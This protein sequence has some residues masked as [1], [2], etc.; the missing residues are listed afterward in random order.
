[1]K[2]EYTTELENVKA[3]LRTLTREANEYK[4]RAEHAERKNGIDIMNYLQGDRL[5]LDQ[6]REN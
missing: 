3:E 1:M 4:Q 5:P 6:R 2:N